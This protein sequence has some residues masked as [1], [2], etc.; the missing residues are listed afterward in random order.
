MTEEIEKQPCESLISIVVPVY[1]EERNIPV[2]A[3]R[4]KKIIKSIGCR[5]E[6]VFAMDPS[7]DRS[8]DVVMELRKLDPGIKLLKMSRRF[9]QPACTL[10]GIYYC[11][12][13]VCVVIDVDLQDPPELIPEMMERYRAGYD[14]VYA[15]RASR[16]GETFFK[17]CV[18]FWGYWLID[19]IADVRIP[20]NTGDFRLLS[21]RVIEHLRELKEHDAFLRG[22]VAYVGFDQIAVQYKRDARFAGKGNYN[23]FIGSLRIG[24]N[25]V[26]GFS[27]YPLHWISLMGFAISS[28]SFLLGLTYLFLKLINFDIKWGNPTLVIL[29][30]FLSGIQ[31]LS[32]GIISE[33]IA[34]TFDEIKGRPVYIVQEAHGFSKSPVNHA[35][36][37]QSY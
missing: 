6:I 5:Y 12:G 37:S 2:F 14:V 13:D 29:I 21:R 25:G 19:K 30:S 20:R 18:A 31:L 35:R 7:T 23:R 28:C 4:V 27:K 17:R 3:E 16:E 1:N 26:L 8:E 33:Y 15:Q 10:A 36:D 22:L 24:L 32:L 34:R 11:T 9:G